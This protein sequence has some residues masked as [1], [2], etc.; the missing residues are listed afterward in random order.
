L[1]DVFRSD[2][3]GV[4]SSLK[5]GRLKEREANRFVAGQAIPGSGGLL[6]GCVG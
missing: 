2:Q 1:P 5:R 4:M 3:F 6:N